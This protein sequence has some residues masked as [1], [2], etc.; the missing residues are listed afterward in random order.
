MEE[1]A[2]TVGIKVLIGII[3][4]ENKHSINLFSKC[5]YE[6]CAHYKQIGEKFGRTLDVVAFQ[7]LI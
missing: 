6:K 5:E 7:K 4:G 2:K 3:A 1:E